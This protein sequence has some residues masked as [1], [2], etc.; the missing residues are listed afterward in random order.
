[1]IVRI[2]TCLLVV[3]LALAHP[4]LA[5]EE[6]VA[7]QTQTRTFGLLG[8]MGGLGGLGYGG[9][10]GYGGGF[11]RYPYFYPVCLL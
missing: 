10:G 6:P 8:G 9:Y 11:G 3:C 4:L 5:A 2:A 7:E 1:M